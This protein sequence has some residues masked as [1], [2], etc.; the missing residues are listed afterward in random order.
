MEQPQLSCPELTNLLES[1]QKE[2][3][4]LA[5]KESQKVIK[6]IV[7]K[8]FDLFDFDLFLSS[9]GKETLNNSTKRVSELRKKI[10]SGKIDL[11]R[12]EDIF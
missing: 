10:D 1:K 8:E 2:I 9:L 3:L 5:Q 6:E 4:A 7:E 12:Y 11:S